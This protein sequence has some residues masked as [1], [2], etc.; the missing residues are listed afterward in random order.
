MVTFCHDTRYYENCGLWKNHHGNT[1]IGST[2]H[3]NVTEH[4]GPPKGASM[5]VYND[6]KITNILQEYCYYQ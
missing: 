5:L 1:V 4:K 6:Y 3:V 2:I